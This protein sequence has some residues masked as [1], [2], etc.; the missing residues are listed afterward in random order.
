MLK[1]L[2]KRGKNTS[3]NETGSAQDNP[4]S[5]NISTVVDVDSSNGDTNNSKKTMLTP[6][7]L[8]TPTTPQT[9]MVILIPKQTLQLIPMSIIIIQ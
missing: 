6:I 1:S 7:Q 4:L 2:F 5:D 8:P 3:D 9:P